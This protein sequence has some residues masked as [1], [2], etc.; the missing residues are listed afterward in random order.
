MVAVPYLTTPSISMAHVNTHN[1]G[2]CHAQ[3]SSAAHRPQTFN[4]AGCSR[5]SSGY[6]DWPG[7]EKG[8][9][10]SLRGLREPLQ[11]MHHVLR[12]VYVSGPVFLREPLQQVSRDLYVKAVNMQQGQGARHPVPLRFVLTGSQFHFF[13]LFRRPR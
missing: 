6:L 9:C 4:I 2:E 8:C 5:S 7:G 11:P 1:K 12:T 13:E 10:S 3:K